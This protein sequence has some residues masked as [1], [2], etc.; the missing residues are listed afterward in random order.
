MSC[1]ILANLMHAKWDIQG[2]AEGSWWGLQV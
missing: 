1:L 2:I